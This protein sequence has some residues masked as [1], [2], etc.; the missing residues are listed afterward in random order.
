[1]ATSPY[2]NNFS[3][4]TIGEQRLLEDVIVE[5][6]SIMGH[7]VWYIPREGFNETD[8]L[9]GENVQ[10]KFERAYQL[11]MYLANVE[12]YEGDGDF[13][14]KFG[15]E[16]RDTSNFV[17]SRK[18]FERYVP[19]SLAIR[20]KEGDLVFVPLMRKLFEIKFVE[21]ELMFFSLGKRNPYIYEL[22]CELF[23]Y[24][25]ESIDTGVEEIDEIEDRHTYAIQIDF[26]TGNGNFIKS[27]TVYQGAN[28][29][30]AIAVGHVKEWDRP[31]T[32]L[33]LINI[34]GTFVSNANVVGVTSNSIY[35]IQTQD[36]L[37]DF[38]VYDQ[39]DNRN[40]QDEA[41]TFIDFSDVNPFGI[42]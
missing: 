8:F 12:G 34:Q 10:S 27:E 2:F 28:L 26:S 40:I 3:V 17:V 20:P 11:E 37:E 30:T 29:A 6:I 18:S 15:L 23:R 41:N 1:M 9:F 32:K 35:T 39:Y 25:N 22:R 16:I 36:D 42:P 24:S 4:A 38:A 21:E 5:S 31:N 33:Q 7:D 14:S 13:F 19:S